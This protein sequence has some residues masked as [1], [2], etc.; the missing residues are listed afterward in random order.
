M[1]AAGATSVGSGGVTVFLACPGLS[2][3]QRA[4][5]GVHAQFVQSVVG[6][7]EAYAAAE[8]A[9]VAPLQRSSRPC[10]VRLACRE[11]WQRAVGGSRAAWRPAADALQDMANYG[12]G[13]VGTTMSAVQ[14]RHPQPRHQQSGLRESRHWQHQP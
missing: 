3:D 4:G 9:N 11:Q 14:Q 10:L 5:F 6:A 2:G 1:L 13:N 8:A 12:Y 7:G